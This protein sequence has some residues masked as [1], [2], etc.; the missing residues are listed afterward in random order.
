MAVIAASGTLTYQQLYRQSMHLGY[1]LRQAGAHPGQLIAIVIEKGWEQIVAVLGILFS[2]AAYLPIDPSLPDERLCYLLEHGQVQI[3]L[4]QS[5]VLDRIVWPQHLQLFCIDALDMQQEDLS[6]LPVFQQPEDL[7]YVIYTSG[8]TGL[9]KGVMINHRGAVNT[10]LDINQRFTISEADRVLA[11]SALNFDLSVYDIFGLLAAGGTIVIPAEGAMRNPAVWLEL[12]IQ[13]RVTL[14][15]S[16]PALFQMLIEFT[17]ADADLLQRAC[18]RLVLL[19]GDWIPVSLPDRGRELLPTIDI[20]SLGGATEASIWSILYPITVVDSAWKS[21]PYGRPMLNQRFA[22]L[23]EGLEPCP[24][25]VPGTLYISGIGLAQ[26]YWRDDVKTNAS[27]FLHPH[28]GE[29]LYCTGDLGRYL[30]DGTIEFLG[31]EDFQVKVQGHRIELGEIE[32]TLFLHPS[33]KAAVTI[34][35]TEPRG[36]KR[37][38]SYVVLQ[39]AEESSATRA[40]ISSPYS[41]EKA[42]VSY[43][44]E[45]LRGLS[46]WGHAS[47]D[48]S[49]GKDDVFRRLQLQYG[50]RNIRQDGDKPVIELSHTVQDSA[51]LAKYRERLSYRTFLQDAVSMTQMEVFLSVLALVEIDGLPKYR[52]PSA[53][54]IYPVQVYLSVKSGRIEGLAEGVYY[55]HPQ[56]HQLV[57]LSAH[58]ADMR[59]IH[60]EINQ[61]IYEDSAFTL[62]LIAQTKGIEEQYGDA[63]KD[64]CLLEAGYMSQLLMAEASLYQIGL[65]PV[66]GLNFSAIRDMFLLEESHIFVHALLGGHVD[67]M[68]ATG[69]SFLPGQSHADMEPSALHIVPDSRTTQK[70]ITTTL[71]KF[72]QEKLPEYMIPSTILVLDALPLTANGKVDRNNLPAPVIIES[73]SEEV[74]V[75]PQSELQKNIATI[76]QEMLPHAK[77][78]LHDNFFDLGGNS[79]LMVRAYTKLRK[80]IQQDLSIIE[81]FF[82]YPTIHSLT[83]FLTK[84]QP[85]QAPVPVQEHT[86]ASIRQKTDGQQRDARR[87]HRMEERNRA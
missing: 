8:S 48:A 26:G 75:A 3:V 82:H 80:I 63:A 27:F 41:K 36:E 40:P 18:L 51:L 64:F 70:K 25:W 87:Q 2:G 10:I 65:C 19:S 1:L 49:H 34:A 42:S 55:Y 72:L 21:I 5:G 56:H 69:W 84:N 71:R 33:V 73:N 83:E 60:A 14:W 67:P 79:L 39:P 15:N 45:Q 23:N 22:V 47:S 43:K 31:R 50:Q 16:V 44:V 24:V 37:L 17:E 85:F 6:P 4:T 78:G 29:R 76:W 20:I 28:T 86:V 61:S 58:G 35:V 38:V 74:F 59:H 81:M 52:Y 68:V 62:F 11:L 12:L 77:I 9:P 7:A 46:S 13:E 57:M 32:E 54:G 53:G 30:P 66:G